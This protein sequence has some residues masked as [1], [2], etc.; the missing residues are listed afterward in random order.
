NGAIEGFRRGDY[1]AAANLFQQVALR[2]EELA[3]SQRVDY[4]NFLT[5]NQKALQSRREG[6]MQLQSADQALRAGKT[7]EATALL[8][9]VSTNRSLPPADRQWA[10]QLNQRLQ[11]ATAAAAPAAPAAAGGTGGTSSLV[12][13]RGKLQQARSLMQKGNYDAA[14]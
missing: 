8:R 11:P 7:Q 9:A 3:P 4:Q 2:Y 5:L 12:I 14:S 6:Q 13:A 10:Q 1:E